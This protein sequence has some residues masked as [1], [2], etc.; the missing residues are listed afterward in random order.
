MV[1][2][3]W[4]D[5]DE[6]QEIPNKWKMYVTTPSI[7]SNEFSESFHLNRKLTKSQTRSGGMKHYCENINANA[8]YKIIPHHKNGS[9][10]CLCV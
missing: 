1:S 3:E 8:I 6:K 10:A 5:R 7:I 4:E 2:V 9:N